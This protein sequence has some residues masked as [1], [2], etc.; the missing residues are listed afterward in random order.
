MRMRKRQNVFFIPNFLAIL[1]IPYIC[2]IPNMTGISVISIISKVCAILIY[3]AID[4]IFI[5]SAI[6]QRALAYIRKQA[7]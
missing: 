1:P 2:Y 7:N 4:V 5:L 3:S 6:V